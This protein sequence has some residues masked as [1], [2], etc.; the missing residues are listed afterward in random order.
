MA[1]INSYANFGA[2]GTGVRQSQ[3]R[4]EQPGGG[5][6]QG[7]GLEMSVSRIVHDR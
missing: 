3:A 2:S 5:T 4:L 7:C 1:C 6:I